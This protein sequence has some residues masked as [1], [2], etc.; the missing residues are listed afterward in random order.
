VQRIIAVI[1][2]A[3]VLI[4]SLHKNFAIGIDWSKSFGGSRVLRPKIMRNL[5][6]AGT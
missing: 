6:L 5:F 2:I 1:S 4:F 3:A